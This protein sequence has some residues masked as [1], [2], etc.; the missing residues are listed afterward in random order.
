MQYPDP[1]INTLRRAIGDTDSEN[2]K[3]QTED[4]YYFL[5]DAVSD[6]QASYNMGYTLTINSTA[7]SWNQ[8]L[9]NVPL[10]LFKMKTLILVLESTLYDNLYE[11]GDVQVGDIKVNATNMLKL[12]KEN[13]NELKAELSKLIKNISMNG[14]T[15]YMID[16]YKTGRI[17]NTYSNYLYDE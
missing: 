10:V 4:L 7:A 1:I 15:G 6:V 3:I 9:E 2:Y 13:I 5:Q 17:N 11:S 12:R 16:T 14:A 8:T